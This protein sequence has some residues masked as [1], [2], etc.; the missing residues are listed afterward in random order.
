MPRCLTSVDVAGAEM[1]GIL[2]EQGA[3]FGRRVGKGG[4]N[5]DAWGPPGPKAPAGNSSA[6]TLPPRSS[7][8]PA[9]QFTL[10]EVEPQPAATPA[11]LR[12]E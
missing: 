9:S 8:G 5:P 2:G 4:Y 7:R 1:S 11:V 12:L 3:P 10:R 6:N